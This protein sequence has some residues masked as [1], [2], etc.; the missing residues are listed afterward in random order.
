[1]FVIRLYS[2]ISMVDRKYSVMII[3][4]LLVCIVLISNWFSLLM[5]NSCLVMIVLVNMLGRL[6]VIV[7]ISGVSVLCSMCYSM[8]CGDI[9]LVCVV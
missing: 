6:S 7:V 1:M 9:F 3:G 5:W 8:W 4:R 2:M